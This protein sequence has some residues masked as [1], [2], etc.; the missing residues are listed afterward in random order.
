MKK[1]CGCLNF[2]ELSSFSRDCSKPDG[3]RRLCTDCDNARRSKWRQEN[4]EKYAAQMAR[5]LER[6]RWLSW[7]AETRR[8]YEEANR[9]QVLELKRERNKRAKDALTDG[10][11][12]QRLKA[13]GFADEQ[14]TPQLLQLKREQ[15]STRRASR[16]LKKAI[17]ETSKNTNAVLGNHGGSD[18]A[19]RLAPDSG[20]QPSS[21]CSKGD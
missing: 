8:V 6:P 9:A 2:L 11:V 12:R 5:R 19:G 13:N 3:R 10:Y 7:T 21:S 17:Y 20:K 15:M 16:Q 18:N 14:I 4:P 1:C